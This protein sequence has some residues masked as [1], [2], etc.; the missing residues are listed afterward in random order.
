MEKK[1][2]NT[3]DDFITLL[4]NWSKTGEETISNGKSKTGNVK[5]IKLNLNGNN[6]YM[7]A[8]TA[9]DGIEVFLKNHENNNTWKVIANNRNV[10][11][12]ISNDINGKPIKYLYF[13]SE[14]EG[15][16]EI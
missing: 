8:D 7:N 10:Y 15:Q 2:C 16:R 4:K 6:Y 14:T 1:T 3:K 13:Y 5:W 9:K 11:K 12:K